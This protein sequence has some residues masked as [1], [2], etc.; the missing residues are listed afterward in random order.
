VVLAFL[1]ILAESAGALALI[2]GFTTRIAAIGIGS[3]MLVASTMHRANGFF[4][5]WTGT[6]SGEGFEYHILAF[7][8]AAAL[9]IAGGGRYSLDRAIANRVQAARLAVTSTSN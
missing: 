5:N 4:M 9:V 3:V 1:A 6:Q 2:A 7:A 8:M